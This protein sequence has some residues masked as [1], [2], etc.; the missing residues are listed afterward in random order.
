M[1]ESLP[2]LQFYK[3]YPDVLD[4][5]FRTAGSACFDIHAYLTDKVNSV[6]LYDAHGDALSETPT[7]ILT[8]G[9]RGIIVR[10]GFRVVVPS[11]LIFK[12]PVGYSVRLF[13][14]SSVGIRQGLPLAHGVGV[15]DSDYFG[16]CLLPLH[17][18][19]NETVTI[20]HGDRI[21]QG[22]LVELPKYE[23]IETDVQPEQ[24]TDR[25]GGFGS[26]GK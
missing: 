10:P 15:V 11:G 1:S 6:R 20:G 14:R 16:E 17:N 21:V 3:L 23:L 25:M 22:E 5:Y 8:D 4:P 13:S 12:I 18:V 9:R 19:T 24:T 7:P 2:T 26:T